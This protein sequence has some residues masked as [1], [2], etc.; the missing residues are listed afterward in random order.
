MV[1]LQSYNTLDT[2]PIWNLDKLMS[3]GDLRFLLRQDEASEV[4]LTEEDVTYLKS[5]ADKLFSEFTKIDLTI[6]KLYYLSLEA[7]YDY[8]CDK[9]SIQGANN[10]FSIYLQYVDANYKNF[11]FGEVIFESAQLYYDFLKSMSDYTDFIG[12]RLECFN[13][14][15][16]KAE[17]KH[18][19]D[20]LYEVIQLRDIT[21][22]NIDVK[23]TS[24]KEFLTIRKYATDKIKKEHGRKN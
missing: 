9:S 19:V 16:F 18:K 10:S 23:K 15:L 20:I 24:Y 5:I 8:L 1:Q 14:N 2:I 17:I 6:Q 13:Y 7:Y 4:V 22:Q 3:T 21:N 12:F 11:R